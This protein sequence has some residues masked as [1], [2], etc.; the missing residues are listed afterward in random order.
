MIDIYILVVSFIAAIVPVFAGIGSFIFMF[1][2]QL[3]TIGV[4]IN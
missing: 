2:T 4:Q 3:S 1:Q